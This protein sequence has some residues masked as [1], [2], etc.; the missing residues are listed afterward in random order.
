MSTL[1]LKLW[2]G[3]FGRGRHVHHDVNFENLVAAIANYVMDLNDV[4]VRIILV[5]GSN[6]S[7]LDLG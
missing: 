5:Y 7:L 1:K 4:E 6:H 2:C 3:E